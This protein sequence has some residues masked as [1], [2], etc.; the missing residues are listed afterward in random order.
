MSPLFFILP[1]LIALTF[2]IATATEAEPD[3]Y[4]WAGG[5]KGVRQVPIYSVYTVYCNYEMEEH[6]KGC[7]NPNT[8]EITIQRHYEDKWVPRGCTT[9]IHEIGHA[10]GL[11]EAELDSLKCPNP[12]VD[13]N[14]GQYQNDNFFHRN[15][16]YI[17]NGYHERPDNFRGYNAY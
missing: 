7:Y 9:K 12:H 15:P 11:N 13:P 10:F 8:D 2:P 1:L 5:E 6:T 17:W 16:L 4:V 3:E 14:Q